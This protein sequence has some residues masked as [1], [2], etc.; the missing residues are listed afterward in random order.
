MT[1]QG[2]QFVVDVVVP[3]QGHGFHVSNLMLD[4]LFFRARNAYIDGLGIED[5]WHRDVTP[6]LKELLIR[7]ESEAMPGEPMQ[8]SVW[9]ASRSRRSFVMEQAIHVVEGHRLVATCRSVHVSVSRSAGGAV[10][11]DPVLWDAIE[12]VEKRQIGAEVRA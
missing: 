8:S 6:Q 2:A 10:E 3:D 12:R 9:I 5:L 11:I 1:G 4:E 7:F